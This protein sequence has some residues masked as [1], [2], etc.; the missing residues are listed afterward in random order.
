M[1]KEPM[2]PALAR[3]LAAQTKW[4]V[5][6][7]LEIGE[8]R[9]APDLAANLLHPLTEQTRRAL[10]QSHR[11]PLGDLALGTS[12]AKPGDLQL[13][14]S[15]L[16]LVLNVFEQA[17]SPGAL[18]LA[19]GGDASAEQVR[20]CSQLS[21]EDD[22][23]ACELDV[24]FDFDAVPHTS[25]ARPTALVASYA[26]PYR[27]ARPQHE[28]ANRISSDWLEAERVWAALPMCRQLALDLRIAPKRFEHLDAARLLRAS[29]CLTAEYGYR[30]ARLVHVWYDGGD[31]AATRYRDEIDRFRFR[32]G[33]EVDFR[34]ITWQQLYSLL[35]RGG[36]DDLP[37]LPLRHLQVLRDRYALG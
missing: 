36:G 21:S 15:T 2:N 23:L 18:S 28:P 1:L 6:R 34:S 31:T 25:G 30:G 20:I 10:E 4:A 16:A 11:R 8:A 13:L 19:C 22:R 12:R 37:T 33:G 9:H 17:A 26:E 35:A 14:E 32:A 3:I 27:S 5:N 24:L 7:G 29:A